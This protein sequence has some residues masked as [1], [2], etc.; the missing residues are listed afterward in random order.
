MS[1]KQVNQENFNELLQSEKPV[2]LDFYADWCGPCKML[3]PVLH[4]FAEEHPEYVV[5]KVNVDEAGSLAGIYRVSSI[6]TLVV[7]KGG[8]E[9]NRAVG[10]RSKAQ[11][12]ALLEG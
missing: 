1:V 3:A 6:P 11:L 7:L 5:A 12:V 8:K 4:S 10:A 9:V 2:L